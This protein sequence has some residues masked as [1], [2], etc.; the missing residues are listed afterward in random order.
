M[1]D[2]PVEPVV[3]G[4]KEGG[5]KKREPRK[6]EEGKGVVKAVPAG[7]S[8]VVLQMTSKPEQGPPTERE[9]VLSN[10]KAPRLGRRGPADKT[11]QDEPFAWQSREF[12][13]KKAIGKQVTFVVEN[14]GPGSKEYGHV[15]LLAQQKAPE[16]LAKTIV[17]EGW[18]E[19]RANSR[20]RP[21]VEDLVKAEESAKKDGKGL[22][23]A[24]VPTEQQVR[25]QPSNNNA[26]LFNATKGTPQ[27]GIVEQ[28]ITGSTLR[29]LLLPSFHE[30]K[31]L[32]SGVEAPQTPRDD[33]VPAP[34]SR[35]AKFLTEHY[36]LHRDV[37]VL[38]EGADQSN[39]YGTVTYNGR[40]IGEELL[41]SGLAKFVD[42][43]AA[44]TTYADRL[45]AAERFAKEKKLRLWATYV[46]PAK[47][48][49]AEEKAKPRVGKEF[50]GKV[51]DIQ[52]ITAFA[53]VDAQGNE[54]K[55]NLSSIRPRFS[56]PPPRGAQREPR[57]EKTEAREKAFLVEAKEFLRRRLIGQRVRCVLD[58][59]R[60]SE[61]RDS[62]VPGRAVAPAGDRGFYTAYLDKQNI[63]VALV[64]NG[65]ADAVYHKAGEPRAKDFEEILAAEASAKKSS[66]KF[67]SESAVPH[68]NDLS[69][70]VAKSRQFLP[71]LKRA[72]RLRGVVEYEFSGSRFKVFVPKESCLITLALAGV[73]V[74]RQGE[75]F[76]AEAKKFAREQV[77]QHDIEFEVFAQDKGGNFIG[78]LY[79]NKRS[80]ATSL[81][82]NGLAQIQRVSLAD[83]GLATEY[84]IAEDAAKK[85]RKN[86]WKDYDEAAEEAKRL[87]RL[88]EREAQ[89]KPK[90]ELVDVIV[91]EIVDATTFYV[92][93]VGPEAEQLEDLMKAL[94]LQPSQGPHSP[95]VGEL[96]SAQFSEDD[97]WY[98][99]KVVSVKNGEATVF[100]VDYGNSETLP[101]SRVRPLPSELPKLAH[102]AHQAQLAYVRPPT[103]NEDYGPEA[104]E[105][106][107]ELVWGK[108]VVANIEYRDDNK[109]YL[110]LG[111]RETGVHV[112]GALVKAGL[113]K[114]EKLRG[115]HLQP[116]LDKLREE[117][118]VA[119]KAHLGIYAYG[120]PGS[121]DDE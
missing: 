71:F 22:H 114:V 78:N 40:N 57:D 26:E 76:A 28:V 52:S 16:N 117:E 42:W 62:P 99:A 61:P 5:E 87:K 121:D 46:E 47:L 43:S 109:L 112:N 104:A 54:V 103:L 72:G 85:G 59:T 77:H 51:V 119:R 70:D 11:T 113:A 66:K 84:T 89:M 38:I 116:V 29:V 32:L 91:T 110:S 44:R 60:A 19:V 50:L 3:N 69:L 111:E 36:L 37:Q 120:D 86:V 10:L 17:S 80:L 35:E 41:K 105:Y 101:T 81:L 102:Q 53:V 24:D 21:E 100:Y 12:L 106:L 9:I 58:Y 97:A 82:E 7:D 27:Q 8:L 67:D 98:R 63:A 75:P 4:K 92:Q 34:F 23:K 95:A 18:A 14:K 68:I 49:R 90:Q 33:Q 108:T 115:K 48:S 88:E 65:Y 94:S 74:A 45:R 6:T 25:P 64:E 118:D 20:D 2:V 39:F 30:I 73:R 55:I 13:R 56:G 83:T 31:L 93:V 107:K 96:V 79:L 1:A 15:F